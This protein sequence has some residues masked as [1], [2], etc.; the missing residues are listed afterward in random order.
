MAG[1]LFG[2]VRGAQRCA[3]CRHARLRH[4]PEDAGGC[5]DVVY[6]ERFPGDPGA[7]YYPDRCD[8]VAFTEPNSKE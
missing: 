6:L 4:L 3:R 7:G 2:S 1:P 8:C 5:T